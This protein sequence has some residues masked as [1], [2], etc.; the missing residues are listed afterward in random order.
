[1]RFAFLCLK[2]PEPVGGP[3]FGYTAQMQTGLAF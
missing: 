2:H 1:M 3:G